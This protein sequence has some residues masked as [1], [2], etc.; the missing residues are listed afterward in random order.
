[1]FILPRLP[2][3]TSGLPARNDLRRQTQADHLPWVDG[4]RPPCLLEDGA[5]KHFVCKLRQIF[6]LFR[7]DDM[8][9]N[10]LEIRAQST[11]RSGLL[12]SKMIQ[13][14]EWLGADGDE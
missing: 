12:I 6:I 8:R 2:T 4:A 14:P 11:G 3:R 5:R 9:V 7:L 10:A 1:M 13:P